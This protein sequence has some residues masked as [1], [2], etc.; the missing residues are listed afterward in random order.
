MKSMRVLICGVAMLA[1]AQP[2]HSAEKRATG[3]WQ[4]INGGLDSATKSGRLLGLP[5]AT[6][7]DATMFSTLGDAVAVI[8]MDNGGLGRSAEVAGAAVPHG[9]ASR[10]DQSNGGRGFSQAI[11]G[12][13]P[14]EL[15]ENS[16]V[17]TQPGAKWPA[18]YG[19]P[20]GSTVFAMS[21]TAVWDTASGPWP[22]METLT[23]FNPLVAQGNVAA[24]VADLCVAPDGSAKRASGLLYRVADM[25]LFVSPDAGAQ[26]FPL[27]PQRGLTVLPWYHAVAVDEGQPGHVVVAQKTADS[28][29]AGGCPTSFGGQYPDDDAKFAGQA[30]TRRAIAW[31]TNIGPQVATAI[32]ATQSPATTETAPYDV[33]RAG[34]QFDPKPNG[35]GLPGA[36]WR[37]AGISHL[38]AAVLTAPT[39]ATPAWT[40][41]TCT[42]AAANRRDVGQCTPD[43]GPDAIPAHGTKSIPPASLELPDKSERWCPNLKDPACVCSMPAGCTIPA[44]DHLAIDPRNGFV[45]ASTNVGLLYSPD[46]GR[47]WLRRGRPDDHVEYALTGSSSFKSAAQSAADEQPVG[48][49]VPPGHGVKLLTMQGLPQSTPAD[50]AHALDLNLQPEYIVT[51]VL[52]PEAIRWPTTVSEV[53]FSLQRCPGNLSYPS[54]RPRGTL[55]ATLDLQWHVPGK[56]QQTRSGVFVAVAADDCGSVPPANVNEPLVFRDTTSTIA[57][58]GE[59][60]YGVPGQAQGVNASKFTPR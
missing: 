9:F 27:A 15:M 39:T 38:G 33:D 35:T 20:P 56:P 18:V 2:A 16:A 21:A 51:E 29:D 40:V 11:C 13:Y 28:H 48:L 17:C 47:Q 36:D 24:Q 12:G 8:G 23:P 59:V 6:P 37:Y 7:G 58:L 26:W 3:A 60:L 42:Y 10:W 41:S 25:G 1:A 46:G 57:Q 54:G 44:I 50:D 53:K 55:V 43:I 45:Y 31:T 52:G 32:L 4:L 49:T 5:P 19:G 22:P 14:P 34:A 30:C